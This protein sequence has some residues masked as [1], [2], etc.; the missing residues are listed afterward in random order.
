MFIEDKQN[1]N[2][3]GLEVLNSNPNVPNNYCKEVRK[4]GGVM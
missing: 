2:C 4:Q 1:N 3:Y